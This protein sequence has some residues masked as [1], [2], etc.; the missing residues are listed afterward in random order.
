MFSDGVIFY[1][2][3]A[4]CATVRR[5][6]DGGKFYNP[7]AFYDIFRRQKSSH[8]DG[9]ICYIPTAETDILRRRY[10]LCSDGIFLVFST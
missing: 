3:T 1:I 10:F 7:T 2:S 9:F 5:R 6:F 8:Y 4:E